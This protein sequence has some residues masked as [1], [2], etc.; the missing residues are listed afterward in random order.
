MEIRDGRTAAADFAIKSCA[1]RRFDGCPKR[2][3]EWLGLVDSIPGGGVCEIRGE[4]DG[5]LD[6]SLPDCKILGAGSTS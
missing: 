5:L 3:T 1:N 4:T 6:D 2:T